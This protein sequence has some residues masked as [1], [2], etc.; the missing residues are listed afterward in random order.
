MSSASNGWYTPEKLVGAA[1]TVLGGIDLDPASS[2]EANKTVK[3]TRY[4]TEADDGLSQP[5]EF[6]QWAWKGHPR[7]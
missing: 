5:W 7:A 1:R 6:D 4:F 2:E 3:A